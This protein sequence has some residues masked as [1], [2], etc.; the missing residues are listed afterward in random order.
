V[1]RPGS[2]YESPRSHKRKARFI[3]T[4]Y[5]D[6]LPATQVVACYGLSGI[7][8]R[9]LCIPALSNPGLLAERSSAR[10]R[11]VALRKVGARFACR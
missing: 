7:Q 11:S 8:K 1:E 10:E 2:D 9:A 4:D 6:I 5:P 3:S